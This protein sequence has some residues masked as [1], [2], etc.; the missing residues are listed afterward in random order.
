MCLSDIDDG[1]T[2]LLSLLG[3]SDFVAQFAQAAFVLGRDDS[4]D[5]VRVAAAID[6]T[7]LGDRV[8]VRRELVV[9]LLRERV[10]L[11]IVTPAAADGQAE[12]HG[13]G[14]LDSVEDVLD[15]RLLGDPA[16]LA[17][18]RMVA[19][20]ARRDLL[21]ESRVRQQVARQLLDGELIERHVRVQG[22]DGPVA[23]RP[24]RPRAVS[25]IAVRVGITRRVEPVEH[26]SLTIAWRCEQPI[27]KP[28][29]SIGRRI[30][31][32]LVHLAQRRRDAR[33]I[34]RHSA[35]ER[36]LLGLVRRRQPF[37]RES[38]LDERVDHVA[39]PRGGCRLGNRWPLRRDER[40]VR[41][42]RRAL[43]DPAREQLDLR[44]RDRTV[45]VSWRHHLV[46]VSRSD[47]ANQL[48]ARRLARDDGSMAVTFRFR[49]LLLIEPQSGLTL[50]AVGAVTVKAGVRQDRP[51]VTVEFNFRFGCRSGRRR[52]NQT[53]EGNGQ[54]SWAA[55]A[56]RSPRQLRCHLQET[57][58][59]PSL[60]CSNR[61]PHLRRASWARRTGLE[62][63]APTS[64]KPLAWKRTFAGWEASSRKAVEAREDADHQ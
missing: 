8:E 22:V 27:D 24:H 6:R 53:H 30:G 19:V 20:K 33:Q 13:A 18:E 32:K 39:A 42:P 26:H 50:R 3:A 36:R 47:P 23:P 56:V 57:D 4:F 29:V 60:N 38:L 54:Q 59:H 7:R 9:L 52:N 45:R 1:Q 40:P 31:E 62:T 41:L 51:N 5:G 55:H 14:R 25:L 49:G 2:L 34:E 48:A 11:V 61:F 21:V 28:F 17:V 58:A 37:L 12:P 16:A 15:A 46:G 44:G 10:V 35:D 64:V 63:R 43:V